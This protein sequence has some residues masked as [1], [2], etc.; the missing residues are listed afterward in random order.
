MVVKKHFRVEFPV[1]ALTIMSKQPT[2]SLDITEMTLLSNFR[3][4]HCKNVKWMFQY[5]YI[6]KPERRC[7]ASWQLENYGA[8]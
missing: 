2:A 6:E 3:F 5:Q 4:C 1:R 7:A 8:L